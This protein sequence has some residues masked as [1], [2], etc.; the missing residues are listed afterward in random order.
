MGFIDPHEEHFSEGV[1]RKTGFD[2]RLNKGCETSTPDQFAP[3]NGIFDCDEEVFRS[4]HY[5]GT[6]FRFPLRTTPS[7]LSQTMYSVEKVTNLFDSFMADAHLAL[8]FMRN[9]EA[10]ELYVREELEAQPRRVFRVKISD[11]SAAQLAR[12]RRKEFFAAV[13]PGSHMTEPVT[14][15][16]PITIEVEADG[17]KASH[18]FLATSYCCGGQVSEQFERLLTD[19]DLSYLPLVGVAMALPSGANPQTPNVSGHVFCVLPLP[20]PPKSMTGLPVHVNGFFALSQNRRH[21]KM[22]NVNQEE[23]AK[24]DDKSLLWNCCLLEEAV[25]KA[26]ATLIFQAIENNVPPEAIYK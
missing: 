8:L 11:E 5:N 4:G 22:P 24:L 25:P 20:V 12:S 17:K 10:I 1:N 6:M 2:C 26:Y 16:Y 21:I 18:S 23:R 3:Y 7:E 19:K 14:V 15:T 13:K 9:L